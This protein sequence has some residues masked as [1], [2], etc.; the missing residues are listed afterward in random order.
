VADEVIAEARERV[1]SC[2]RSA[3]REA[4][5]DELEKARP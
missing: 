3:G 5:A 4:E 2:L 1:V